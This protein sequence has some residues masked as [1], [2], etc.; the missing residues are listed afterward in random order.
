[1]YK[2]Q[3]YKDVLP[4]IYHFE[5][6]DEFDIIGEYKEVKADNEKYS[7]SQI[8]LREI[9]KTG[10]KSEVPAPV[11]IDDPS[12]IATG[13]ESSSM[14]Q[15][16]LVELNNVSVT[17]EAD[18]YGEW[19]VEGNLRVDDLFYSYKPAVGTRFIRLAG[20]LHTSS[21]NYKLEPRSREDIKLV[22]ELVDGGDD[23]VVDALED[24][25]SDVVED[26]KTWDAITDIS[27]ADND[28]GSQVGCYYGPSVI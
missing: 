3:G 17:K 14:Y 24:V 5:I 2:R 4:G 11:K 27:D 20:I 18:M 9:V 8:E 21:D 10:N 15:G 25:V 26:T 12:K 22:D 28:T 13:G 16:V 19:T 23:V 1:V 7:N 6:G